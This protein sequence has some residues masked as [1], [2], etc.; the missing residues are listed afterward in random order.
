M[1]CP[2]N[3]HTR[4]SVTAL[5]K[6]Y[7]AKPGNCVGGNLHIVL[8]DGNTED[9]HVLFC[10]EKAVEDGDVDGIELADALLQ[11]SYTQRRKVWKDYASYAPF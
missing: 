10:R 7:Y 4:A 3:S 9:S 11:L 1:I 5:A 6:A 2:T 8:D